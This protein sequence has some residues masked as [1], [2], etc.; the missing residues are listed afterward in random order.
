MSRNV[1][2]GL[3]MA[4]IAAVALSPSISFAENWL[5]F[6]GYNGAG[7][8]TSK[9]PPM[10]WS[11]TENL[12]WSVKLP[13]P[14]ASSPII[15]GDQLFL[16]CYTGYGVDQ[17]SPGEPKD[18]KRH[19]L[20][21][22]RING[23]LQWTA[24]IDS[25]ET[26]D[27]YKGFINQHGYASSTPVS[28]GKYVYV[29]FGKSGVLAF[30]LSGQ[31]VWRRKLGQLSDPHEWGS[32]ASPM[33][34]EDLLIVN[35]GI[36]DHAMIALNKS[37][38]EEAWRVFDESFTNCWATPILVDLKERTEL[39]FASPG[40]I[41]ALDPKS[42]KEHWRAASPVK[43]AVSGS[44]NQLDGVVYLMGGRQGSAIAIRCGGS[45]DVSATNTVWDKS[46]RSGTGTPVIVDRK[47]YW[48]S[49]GLAVCADCDTGKEIFK[50]RIKRPSGDAAESGGRG[51]TGDYASAIAIDNNVLIVSRSGQ[52]Q[53]WKAEEKYT[54]IA[55]SAFS[56]D[57]G[58]FNGTPAISDGC[59]YIRSDKKLYC[60]GK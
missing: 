48:T 53:L 30:D 59:I 31:E 23:E 54:P 51:P 45:G 27:P 15:V 20:S 7:I 32:G 13:G 49:S 9:A 5:R 10:T 36:T 17:T 4:V 37:T 6:R 34:Y 21:F 19:L 46:L 57:E 22:N 50:E 44:L 28:D 42:G 26:E 29:V 55:D 2:Q 52:S 1:F 16:T 58:P 43:E 8:S 25:N 18:L 35:A 41:F 40:R 47:L 14:G 60:V 3:L 39:V 56:D 24:T 11:N 38:G 12:K 33:L